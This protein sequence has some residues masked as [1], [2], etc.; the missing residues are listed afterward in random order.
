MLEIASGKTLCRMEE[1]GNEFSDV[2]SVAWLP[3]GKRIANV[4]KTDGI[5]LWDAASGRLLGKVDE[6]LDDGVS[7]GRPTASTSLG[8]P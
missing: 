2:H 6:S 1:T 5:K 4:N 7:A 8:R 3:D